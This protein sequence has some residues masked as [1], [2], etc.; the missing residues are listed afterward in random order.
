MPLV[1]IT[2]YNVRFYFFWGGHLIKRKQELY[3]K[4]VEMSRNNDDTTANL[5]DLLYQQNCYKLIDTEYQDKQ[6][7]T[8]FNKLIS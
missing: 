3:E 6:I 7:Q 8:L 1:E 2:G 4:I 5:A